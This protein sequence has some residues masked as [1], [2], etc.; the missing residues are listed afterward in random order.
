MTIIHVRTLAS[1]TLLAGAL[2]LGR[3]DRGGEAPARDVHPAGC[4][5]ADCT[6]HD[7]H[8]GDPLTH[9]AGCCSC[10]TIADV[11]TL[12]S[13]AERIVIGRVTHVESAWHAQRRLI[14]THATVQ[15]EATLKG[16]PAETLVVSSLGGTVGD[17]TLVAS[18][19]QP[20]PL[21]A[22][23]ALFLERAPGLDILRTCYSVQG[24]MTVATLDGVEM[25]VPAMPQTTATFAERSFGGAVP[26]A[27]FVA[28]VATLT[29]KGAARA[30]EVR[31]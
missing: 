23:V 21:G 4:H 7:H 20:L 11:A 8:H 14:F 2:L 31:R 6:A 18:S 24:A 26:R 30:T 1:S 10:G 16:E 22:H 27:G 9:A 29:A 17:T 19:E 13:A 3:A 15:V 28:E 5:H 25:V 12:T